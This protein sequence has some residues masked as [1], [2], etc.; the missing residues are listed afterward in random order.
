MKFFLP[1]EKRFVGRLPFAAAAS[2]GL[3]A[4]VGTAQSLENPKQLWSVE[5]VLQRVPPRMSR[6]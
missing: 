3:L 5:A 2:A 1:G 6:L 4:I